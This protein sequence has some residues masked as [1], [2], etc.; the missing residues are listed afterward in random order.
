MTTAHIVPHQTRPLD[1]I[2]TIVIT[3]A[4]RSSGI[5]QP[6][7]NYGDCDSAGQQIS[8]SDSRIS[9]EPTLK[10][11]PRRAFGGDFAFLNLFHYWS[12]ECRNELNKA[13]AFLEHF[14]ISDRVV[15]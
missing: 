5:L 2:V 6:P 1:V 3:A 9:F 14:G 8:S 7:K 15:S 11:G 4:D 13:T 10:S 12:K